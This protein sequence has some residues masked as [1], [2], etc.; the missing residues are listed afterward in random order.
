M[1][2]YVLI[3]LKH[4]T[5]DVPVFWCADDCGYT[6]NPFEAGI[7]LE[8]AIKEDPDYYN[9]GH[10]ALAVEITHSGLKS[11]GLKCTVDLNLVAGIVKQLEENREVKS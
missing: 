2:K 11:A 9:D 3:S 7:Y 8:D 6:Q 1:K 10:N 5:D 4:T